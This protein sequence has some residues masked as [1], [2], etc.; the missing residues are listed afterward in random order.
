MEKDK[1]LLGPVKFLPGRIA[2][3]HLGVER[4]GGYPHFPIPLCQRV[5]RRPGAQEKQVG[6]VYLLD[7]IGGGAVRREIELKPVRRQEHRFAPVAVLHRLLRHSP[8]GSGGNLL[9]GG[10]KALKPVPG[11][12]QPDLAVLL[13][14]QHGGTGLL[15]GERDGLLGK[16][17][18]GELR[19]RV[20]VPGEGFPV[21]LQLVEQQRHRLAGVP[22]PEAVRRPG[23][24]V[25]EELLQPAA[26]L[27]DAVV[28]QRIR[29]GLVGEQDGGIRPE[30]LIAGKDPFGQPHQI[31]LPGGEGQQ[32]VRPL[33]RIRPP[34]KV[35]VL[36]GGIPGG[37]FRH[38]AFGPGGAPF[39]RAAFRR[40]PGKE[41]QSQQGQG[42]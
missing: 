40:A 31:L 25:F 5:G 11:P 39:V 23:G 26:L 30:L 6:T 21:K 24:Q 29:E 22:V 17:P 1:V 27:P 18:F 38:G 2:V 15:P 3:D 37:S 14:E 36:P 16:Q 20:E 12:H 41:H 33:R 9:L 7:A 35:P 34:G 32:P 19:V 10:D 13:P 28:V 8:A 42:D 4:E